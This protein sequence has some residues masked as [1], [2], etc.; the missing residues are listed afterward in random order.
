MENSTCSWGAVFKPDGMVPGPGLRVT[1]PITLRFTGSE[2]GEFLE[3]ITLAIFY[4]VALQAGVGA[5]LRHAGG[6]FLL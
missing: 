3:Y 4:V 2:C 6:Q 1:R 5:E